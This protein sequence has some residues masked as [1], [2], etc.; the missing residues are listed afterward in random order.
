MGFWALAGRPEC[1][2]NQSLPV[3]ILVK[4]G[5]LSTLKGII[6]NGQVVL[7]QPTDLP[8]GTEV[9]VV[10][11]GLGLATDDESGSDDE[12]ARTLTAMDAVEPFEM[13]DDERDAISRDRQA[14]K[15]WDKAHFNERSE[16]LRGMWK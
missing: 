10:P 13:S 12:I 1:S 16:Q 6:H 14:R 15:E 5:H 4:G 8:E 7:P 2:A 3:L 11:V 9:V